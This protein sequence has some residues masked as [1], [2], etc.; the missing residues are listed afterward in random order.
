MSAV[1]AW[2][3]LIGVGAL[4][5]ATSGAGAGLAEEP[6]GKSYFIPALEVPGFILALNVFSR[7]V[8]DPDVYGTINRGNLGF[9]VRVFGPHAIGVQYLVSTRDAGVPGQRDRQQSLQTVSLS[10]NFLGHTRFGAV[11]WRSDDATGR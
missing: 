11:E 8:I 1:I 4:I 10:Y 6:E 9:T 7:L 3:F 2:S 5:L